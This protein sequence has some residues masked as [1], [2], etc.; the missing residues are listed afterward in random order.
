MVLMLLAG[1]PPLSAQTIEFAP[2]GGYRFGGDLFEVVAAHPLD[3]DGAPALGMLLDVPLSNGL[4]V[5]GLFSHQ[6]ASVLVPL[7]PRGTLQQWH[8]SVQQYQ[9]GALQEF[10]VERVR[11]FATATFGL[12]HYAAPGDSE[13]RFTIGAGGGAK[14]FA[15][16]H[17][18]VRLDGRVFATFLDA[19]GSAVACGFNGCLLALH[20]NVVWQAEFTAGLFV[21]LR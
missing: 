21:R 15:T 17:V 20:M 7:Q 1:I 10:G 9:A 14:L 6:E 13:L 19:G 18:G 2:Y 11:P 8:V 5:E 4:H 16:P 12:T 3:I